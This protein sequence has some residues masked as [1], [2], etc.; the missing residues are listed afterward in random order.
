MKQNIYT[1]IKLIYKNKINK[2]PSFDFEMKII[3]KIEVS[4]HRKSL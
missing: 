3:V 1:L 4:Q 2:S